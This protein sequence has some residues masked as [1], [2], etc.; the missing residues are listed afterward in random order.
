MTLDRRLWYPARIMTKRKKKTDDKQDE[1]YQW[2]A[3]RESRV[4]VETCRHLAFVDGE[5]ACLRC[6]QQDLFAVNRS[7]P[8]G[9][10]R[11]KKT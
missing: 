1:T 7:R 8:I 3:I 11:R 10:S 4:S 2:C 6:L 9:R 5:P